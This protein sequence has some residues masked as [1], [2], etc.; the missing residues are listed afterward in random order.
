MALPRT[1]IFIV[2]IL[3]FNLLAIP[4]YFWYSTHSI[5]DYQS[6]GNICYGYG[7]AD[8]NHCHADA[9][10]LSYAVSGHNVYNPY[11]RY[12]RRD[13]NCTAD[14]WSGANA[15]NN[16]VDFLFYSGHGWGSGPFLGCNQQYSITSWTDIRF[17]SGM[18]LKWVQAAACE[19]FV[20]KS[21]DPA[22]SGKTEFERWNGCFKGVHVIQAHRAI[23]YDHNYSN[24]MSDE[25]FDRWVDNGESIYGSWCDAQINWVYTHAGNPGL[26]PATAAQSS[27]YA[28]ETWA[29]ATDN[30]APDGMHWLSWV[31]AGNPEY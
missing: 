31:T 7:W 8:L 23:T 19:W 10:G 21:V 30:Q 18:Y 22:G 4:P 24:E 20:D 5:E 25:F 27:S 28:N 2:S 3:S 12:N 29:N 16:G 11:Y 14:K 26:Q 6:N 17:G 15:E 9:D 13:P 1:L